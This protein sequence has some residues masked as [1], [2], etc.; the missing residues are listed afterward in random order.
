MG[1]NMGIRISEEYVNVDLGVSFGDSGVYDTR[2]ETKGNL[3]RALQKEFGKATTM[4]VDTLS[5]P[6]A[7]GWVFTKRVKY[8]DARSGD[9]KAYYTQETWV[10]I[11]E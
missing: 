4:Y 2:H 3:F 1:I 11:H 5:G 6:K 8:T 10:T 7:I 9:K